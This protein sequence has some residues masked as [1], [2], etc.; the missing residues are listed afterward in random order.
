MA[1]RFKKRKPIT[2]KYKP[3]P[4]APGPELSIR[5]VGE[6][7]HI[8][9]ADDPTGLDIA[10]VRA[11]VLF[12][13]LRLELRQSA[14]EFPETEDPCSWARLYFYRRSLATLHEFG[15][16]LLGIDKLQDFRAALASPRVSEFQPRWRAA[17]EHFRKFAGKKG[18]KGVITAARDDLGGHFGIEAARKA[19]KH[20]RAGTSEIEMHVSDIDQK[21]GAFLHFAQSFVVSV[22]STYAGSGA[23]DLASY[24]KSIKKFHRNVVHAGYI[25]AREAVAVLVVAVVWPRF[26]GPDIE[27]PI[28]SKEQR[29]ALN[30]C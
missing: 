19:L 17:V 2:R 11:S 22:L 27:R 21:G 13:D 8:F 3:T 20:L 26:P 18:R 4:E 10:L 14:R 28:G 5:R 9:N 16:V 29:E 15:D 1:M 23:A 6:L 24:R 12:E 30:A 7:R 25:H